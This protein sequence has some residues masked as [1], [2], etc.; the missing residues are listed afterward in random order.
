MELIKKQTIRAYRASSKE[1]AMGFILAAGKLFPEKEQQEYYSK[2]IV[3]D[4]KSAF[5]QMEYKIV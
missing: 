5:R 2:T 1:E 4:D 3:V